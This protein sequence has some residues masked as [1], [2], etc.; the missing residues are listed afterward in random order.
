MTTIHRITALR[1][2]GNLDEARTLILEA[3][4]TAEGSRTKAAALLGMSKDTLYRA[5]QDLDMWNAIDALVDAKGWRL[6]VGRA[7]GSITFALLACVFAHGCA[8]E[9]DGEEPTVD[10]GAELAGSGALGAA[11]SAAPVTVEAGSKAPEVVLEVDAGAPV[12]VE[13]VDP[14]VAAGSGGAGGTV[15]VETPA[16]GSGGVGGAGGSVAP[17]A[18]SGGNGEAGATV[19]GMGGSAAPAAGSGGSTAPAAITK[20]RLSSGQTIACDMFS[21]QYFPSWVVMWN[22]SNGMGGGSTYNCNAAGAPACVK[23]AACMVVHTD[24]GTS[25]SGLCQ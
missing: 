19:A 24:L 8:A 11:G 15:A 22:V 10:A 14:P 1:A 23:G 5:I 21:K 20:C 7:R 6:R 25:E 16:A 12:T 2:L 9:G 18:G 4:T 3:I 13:P 17:V